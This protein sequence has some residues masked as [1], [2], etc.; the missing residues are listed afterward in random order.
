MPKI[1]DKRVLQGK[2]NRNEEIRKYFAKRW[3]DGMRYEVIEEEV[4]LKWGVSASVITKIM[5][6]NDK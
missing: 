2:K 1:V 4:I 6:G 5:Q 3:K